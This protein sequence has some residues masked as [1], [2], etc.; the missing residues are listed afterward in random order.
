MSYAVPPPPKTRPSAVDTASTLLW[1]VVATQVI[2]L[3]VAL[4]PNDKLSAALDEFNRDHP[5]FQGSETFTLIAGIIGVGITT[6]IAVSLGVLAVFLRRGSQPARVT[7]WVLGGL[8]A[9]CQVCGLAG[10]ALSSSMSGNTDNAEFDEYTRIIEENTPAWQTTANVILTLIALGAL[11]AVI[12]LLALPASND[13]FRKQQEVWVPPTDYPG[14]GGYGQTP[15][16][17]PPPGPPGPPQ[18]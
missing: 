5:D 18:P 4:L 8:L 11:I 12:V 17:A 3:I 14:G 6:A 10:T 7:T 1:V 9:L 13:Y 16:M 15:P 2:S